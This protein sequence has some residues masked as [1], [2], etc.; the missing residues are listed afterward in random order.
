MGKPIIMLADPDEEYLG[1]LEVRFYAEYGDSIEIHMITEQDFFNQYFREPHRVD[2]MLVGEQFYHAELLQWKIPCVMVLSDQSEQAGQDA[3]GIWHIW[4]YSSEDESF[5]AILQFSQPLLT[6][7]V[8]PKTW[9]KLVSV[10]SA[11]GG[12]GKTTLAL[13]LSAALVEEG[14]RVLY[15]DAERLN[16]FQDYL[17][18]ALPLSAEADSL[19]GRPD[20]YPQ[21]RE[22]L[23]NAGF[24]YLPPLPFNLMQ[25]KLDFSVYSGFVDSARRSGDF[26]FIIVDMDTVFDNH[27]GYLLSISDQ[28]LL[29]TD[30]RAASLKATERMY[31][32]MDPW[33]REKVFGIAANSRADAESAL[34][35]ENLE[36]PLKEWIP[37]LEGLENG[38]P[39][40]WGGRSELKR[41]TRLL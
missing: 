16:H 25:M 38:T 22:Q 24:A 17:A 31:R 19:L 37:W 8:K 12:C 28:I 35:A 1:A 13:S 36:F 18:G 32:N 7:A 2:V 14:K 33:M 5:S 34:E 3:N 30:W 39:S 6:E 40:E 10:Y 4:K 21:L 20:S 9:A 15:V 41:L 27:K 29:L 23:G 11:A 26:D